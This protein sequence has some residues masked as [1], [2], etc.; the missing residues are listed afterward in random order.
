[1]WS[2]SIL[3]AI[4]LNPSGHD[5]HYTYKAVCVIDEKPQIVDGFDCRHMVAVG[6]FKNAINL[7]GWSYLEIETKAGFDPELQAY[8]AG[9]LEGVLSRQVLS[10]N[11]YNTQTGYCDGYKKYC[12]RLN[13]YLQ[14]NLAWIRENIEKADPN[15][16]YWQ[17]V[18]RTF[19]QLTGLWD[20]YRD[21]SFNPNISYELHPIMLTNILAGETY[22]LEKKFNRTK[23]LMSN[24]GKCSGFVKITPGN[25]DLLISQVT[26]SGLE[27]LLRVLKL[28]KFGYDSKQFP[29]HTATFSSYPGLLY[30][31]DDFVLTSAGLAGI[32]TTMNLFKTELYDKIEAKNQLQCWIRAIVANQLAKTGKE[33]CQIFEKFNS[34]TYNNQWTI[35]DYK[36]FTPGKEIPNEGLLYVLEQMP[37][38]INYKDMTSYLKNY[39]YFASYNIPFFKKTSELSGWDKKAQELYWFS[40]KDCPRAKIFARDN[41]QVVDIN[42][43]TKLMRYNDYTHEVFSKCNCTPPYTAEA[44]ISARGDLNLINGTYQLPGM[45]H[46]NHAALDYKGTNY[47][48]FKQFRFRAWSGPTYDQVPVF[49]WSESDFAKTV[50]HIGHPD[51]WNFTW[52]EYK[53]ETDNIRLDL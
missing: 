29:G 5:Q 36:L 22:E 28:Y 32:E 27:H 34:G 25:K 19:Y 16:V 20:G 53:W 23:D 3:L 10:F 33:W 30:S 7:T 35:L 31:S 46:Q 49:K 12:K 41:G 38:Y 17:A 40:W 51:V 24:E 4:L 48:M 44:A 26:M 2:K 18:K 50:K 13:A 39:S 21:A 14:Q 6:R 42:S 15:D 52:V 47:D 9:I 8:A 45:G 43:L 1:M 11:I 37:G